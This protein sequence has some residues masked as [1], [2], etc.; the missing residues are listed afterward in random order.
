MT[1]V[2]KSAE[3]G[4]GRSDWR[5]AVGRIGDPGATSELEEDVA[6]TFQSRLSA[7]RGELTGR[8]RGGKASPTCALLGESVSGRDQ[9]LRRV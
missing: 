3:R 1:G 7:V 9:P 4:P 6:E 2:Y 8:R 5:Y